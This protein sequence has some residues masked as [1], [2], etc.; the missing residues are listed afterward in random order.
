VIGQCP[1]DAVAAV[2]HTGALPGVALRGPGPPVESQPPERPVEIAIISGK[3]GTG[4]T[5]ITAAFAALASERVLADADVDA[6]DLHLVSGVVAGERHELSGGWEARVDSEMCNGCGIFAEACRSDA[7]LGDGPANEMIDRT[8]RV[9]PRTCEGCGLCVLLC[10]MDA[11]TLEPRTTGSWFVS[12]GRGGPLVHARLAVGAENSGR[13]V[14]EVRRRAGELAAER[15][16]DLRLTDGPPGTGCPVIATLA[17]IDLAVVVTE[18]TISGVHDLDRVLT[19]AGRSGVPAVV[20]VNQSDTNEPMTYR[21]EEVALSFGAPVIAHIP[22]DPMVV[23]AMR[24]GVT[25][26][27]WTE[28]P[29]ARAVRVAWRETLRSVRPFI[30]GRNR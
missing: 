4:K 17:G 27:E 19:L 9:D 8:W 21:I 20:V 26:V 29:A 18:P 11:I 10:P 24:A 2:R 25:V 13:L 14:T 3:G 6:A 22:F 7:L 28:G 12:D 15:R 23:A 1:P 5:T 30:T 16:T